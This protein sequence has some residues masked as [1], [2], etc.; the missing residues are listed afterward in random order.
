MTAQQRALALSSFDLD[1]N[2]MPP[3]YVIR[4]STSQE[5]MAI[6]IQTFTGL[7]VEA[8]ASQDMCDDS[9]N[10]ASPGNTPRVLYLHIGESTQEWEVKSAL[11][12]GGKTEQTASASN[13]MR[14]YW[15]HRS[16]EEGRGGG[17]VLLGEKEQETKYALGRTNAE[18][19]TGFDAFI[20]WMVDNLFS[21]GRAV[22]LPS[23]ISHEDYL[24]LSREDGRIEL[25]KY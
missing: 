11:L 25:G 17:G 2:A 18:K 19:Q 8:L 16:F 1:E 24:T 21:E 13:L 14:S 15:I 3:A 6:L 4:A 23:K 12:R 22:S 20:T 5:E 10:G 7:D 9:K